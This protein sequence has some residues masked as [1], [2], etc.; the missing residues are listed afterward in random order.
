MITLEKVRKVYDNGKIAVDSIDAEFSKKLTTI[1]GRNGAGKTTLIRM[2]STQLKPTSGKITL[3][4]IDV[5]KNPREARK[6]ICSIP[7]ESSP[8][9][10][11]TPY[12]Q[13]KMYLIGRGFSP[14]DAHR[15]TLEALETVGLYDVRNNPTDT[16]S[17]GM[18]RKMYVAISISSHAS[19]VF[20]DE[21]TTGLDP[22]S[23]FEVWS[24]IRKLDSNVVLT[25]HYMEEAENL[26]QE[27]YL[28]ESGKIIEK[29]T[30]KSLLSRFS[31][32]VRVESPEPID[33]SFYIGGMNIK[34]VPVDDA[35]EYVKKG[36]TVKKATL[37]DLF[38]MKGVALES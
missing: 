34:Y 5:V 24:A 4:G 25:T 9:G 7:Q 26:S 21:P 11:L 31:N 8:L 35:E 17:G 29:G 28:V 3:D 18:K 10:I 14:S 30:I 23:R 19:T 2:M 33:G 32:T 38:I 22:L 15:E 36:C 13:V 20:L 6:K 16:M 1:I 27:V 12:E 37:D